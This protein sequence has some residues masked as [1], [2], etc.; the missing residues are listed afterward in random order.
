M[1]LKPGWHLGMNQRVVCALKKMKHHTGWHFGISGLL[2]NNELN[3]RLASEYAQED[4]LTPS[5]PWRR[6]AIEI[7]FGETGAEEG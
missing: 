3:G 2:P 6:G 4:H 1:C 7:I 5:F